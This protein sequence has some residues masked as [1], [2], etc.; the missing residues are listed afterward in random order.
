MDDDSGHIP[1]VDDHLTNCL[2]ISLAVQSLG[3]TTALAED[4]RQALDMLRAEPFDLILLDIIMPIMNGHQVLEEMEADS[5][6]R[7]IP[8]I[9]ISCSR[10]GL[11]P[12]W[13][14][15]AFA[16]GSWNTCAILTPNRARR[17]I[18]QPGL[19]T[20]SF[21][22]HFTEKHGEKDIFVVFSANLC[23]SQWLSVSKPE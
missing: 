17:A 20:R 16:T 5:L 8:V 12:A 22:E 21:T 6:L 4:G 3:H 7:N 9:V 19:V 1:V 2:K 23:A 15:N 13:T 18:P 10:P 11:T 14:R